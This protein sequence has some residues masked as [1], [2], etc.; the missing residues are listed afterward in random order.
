MHPDEPQF[1]WLRDFWLPVLFL[2][3]GALIGSLVGFFSTQAAEAKRARRAKA[4][5]LRAVKMELDGLYTDLDGALENV[6]ESHHTFNQNPGNLRVINAS[7]RTSVYSSQL[8]KLSD[9]ADPLIVEIIHFYSDFEIVN[10]DVEHLRERGISLSELGVTN[11]LDLMVA[12]NSVNAAYGNL[13]RSIERHR[14]LANALR[15]SL[16]T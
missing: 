3:I 6:R 8:S 10:Q 15:K 12:R 2:A 5:F 1:S 16:P 13:E 11:E 14:D 7:F 9:A 4:A